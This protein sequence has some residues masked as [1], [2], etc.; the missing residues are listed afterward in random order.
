[1]ESTKHWMVE[2]VRFQNRNTAD[3]TTDQQERHAKLLVYDP[4]SVRDNFNVL[5]ISLKSYTLPLPQH[6]VKQNRELKQPV[7]VQQVAPP[8]FDGDC[9]SLHI[10]IEWLEN[11]VQSDVKS[12][13]VFCLAQ[14]FNY[15]TGGRMFERQNKVPAKD[16]DIMRLCVMWE[17]LCNYDDVQR[18]TSDITLCSSV[19]DIIRRINKYFK[20]TAR[21]EATIL[22]FL[23]HYD[24]QMT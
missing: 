6:C 23:M 14:T 18:A 1:M 9:I 24:D 10:T 17:I 20:A 4:L 12:S 5:R 19:R 2:I 22:C 7:V 13:G 16:L 3:R 11:P 8:L 15:I 21:S